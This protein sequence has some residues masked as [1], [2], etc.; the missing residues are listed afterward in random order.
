MFVVTPQGVIFCAFT[1][2]QESKICP[3]GHITNDMDP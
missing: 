3:Y 2:T 1:N